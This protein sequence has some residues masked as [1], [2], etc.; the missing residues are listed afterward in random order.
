M[1]SRQKA[2]ATKAANR[3]KY[4]T[5]V[6]K[7]VIKP[8][9]PGFYELR[10]MGL[11]ARAVYNSVLATSLESHYHHMVQWILKQD[12]VDP[13][14]LQ[15]WQ[16]RSD[17]RGFTCSSEYG[18]GQLAR[19]HWLNGGPVMGRVTSSI[20]AH[21]DSKM[22]T[23]VVQNSIVRRITNAWSA[24]RKT[25]DV[26]KFNRGQ[27][28]TLDFNIQTISKTALRQGKI[29]LAGVDTG[30]DIGGFIA[31]NDVTSARVLFTHDVVV[32]EV[33]YRVPRES[34]EAPRWLKMRSPVLSHRVR[35][36]QQHIPLVAGI[37]LGVARLAT[38]AFNHTYMPPLSYD[39]SYA[40]KEN[41]W[42]NKQNARIKSAYASLGRD[43]GRSLARIWR[44]RNARISHEIASTAADIV[45]RLYFMGV[46]KIVIGWS[47]GFKT[48]PVMGRKNNQSFTCM[49]LALLRD[50][51]VRLASI[52][53]LEAEVMEESYSS[54]ASFLDHDEVPAYDVSTR[55]T[56]RF[57]GRRVKRGLYRAGDGQTIHADV[58]GALNILRKSKVQFTSIQDGKVDRSGV[59]VAPL[60]VPAVWRPTRPLGATRNQLAII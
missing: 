59:V 11:E 46:S 60:G 5:R 42:A 57:S 48:K 16:E 15:R 51:I 10:A 18:V 19:E 29:V 32:V 31:P 35:R 52:V 25:G 28:A 30:I 2:A 33:L 21:R 49:P 26:P 41:Q 53:G 4:E 55:G 39:G 50:A 6:S 58:N 13:D 17:E 45:S 9:D 20:I 54:K 27:Y 56:H 7:F 38:V 23:K 8:H 36:R 3:A 1:N 22:N 40:K 12:K 34:E 47:S 37:D 43:T 44:K 24:A 14:A